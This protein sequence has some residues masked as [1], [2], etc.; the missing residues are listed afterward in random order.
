[1]AIKAKK[2]A[3]EEGKGPLAAPEGARRRALAWLAGAGTARV[4][5]PPHR[6]RQEDRHRVNRQPGGSLVR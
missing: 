3:L 2:M 6:A 5:R 4:T 1:M